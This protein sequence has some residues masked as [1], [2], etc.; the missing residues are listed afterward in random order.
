MLLTNF[1]PHFLLLQSGIPYSPIN[2][3]NNDHSRGSNPEGKKRIGHDRKT[4][5]KFNR[6]LS[7]QASDLGN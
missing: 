4:P 1:V 6:Y 3:Q 5:S 2:S 7:P